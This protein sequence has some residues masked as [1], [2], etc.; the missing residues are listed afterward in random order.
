M[1]KKNAENHPLLESLYIE[2]SILHVQGEGLYKISYTKL[3][4]KNIQ[5]PYTYNLT[6]PSNSWWFKRNH[7]EFGS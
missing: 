6:S 5:L 4:K 7:F 2:K 3:K 1:T